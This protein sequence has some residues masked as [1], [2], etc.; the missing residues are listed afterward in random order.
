VEKQRYKENSKKMHASPRSSDP[1]FFIQLLFFLALVKHC[2]FH[3]AITDCAT[4]RFYKIIQKQRQQPN[5]VFPPNANVNVKIPPKIR[6]P[7]V[8]EHL[9]RKISLDQV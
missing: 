8:S 2:D 3:Y 5:A 4:G 7:F 1:L 6:K 9:H